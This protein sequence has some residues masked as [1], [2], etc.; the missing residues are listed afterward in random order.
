MEILELIEDNPIT[1]RIRIKLSQEE[2]SQQYSQI[3]SDLQTNNEIPGFRRGKAPKQIV[4]RHVGK[5]EIWRLTCKRASESA[6]G[7][8][9][10]LLKKTSMTY[11]DYQLE[12]YSQV[13]RRL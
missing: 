1:N 6:F 8:A 11:P 5:P 7:E 4:E 9:L 3:L 2:I 13:P 12:T 10:E